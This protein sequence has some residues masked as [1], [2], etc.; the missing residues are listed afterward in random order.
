YTSRMRKREIEKTLG[1]HDP[2]TD[3]APE[4]NTRL[5]GW[6]GTAPVF[7]RLIGEVRPLLI[8]EIGGWMGQSTCTMAQSLRRHGCDDVAIITD[9]TWLGSVEHWLQADQRANM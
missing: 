4:P 8:I 1:L 9:D 5:W 3:F 6:N 7:D 2:F